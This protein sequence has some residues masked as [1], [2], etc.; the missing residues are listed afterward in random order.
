MPQDKNTPQ[1][2]IRERLT[3]AALAEVEAFGFEGVSTRRVANSCGVSCAA[4]YKHFKNKR[5]LLVAVVSHIND[6]WLERQEKTLAR[7]ADAP[8]R[9]Q[10]VE[11]S[12]EYVRFMVENPS[13]LAVWT[14]KGK[15]DCVD[16]LP[17][18]AK[19]SEL[20]KALLAQ[21]C[22]EFGVSETTAR[23]KM[24]VVRSLIYGAA[25]MFCNG[26]LEYDEDALQFVAE[27]VDREFDLI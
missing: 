22:E 2:S 13:F 18:K 16:Y 4:P 20:S 23:A 24:Y 5:E 7:F 12:L 26:D 9:R 6:R 14:A 19:T 17:I 10:L 3:L 11:L 15:T 25:L 27:F 1:P 8:I 21:Y